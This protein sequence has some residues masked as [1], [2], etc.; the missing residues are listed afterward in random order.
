MENQNTPKVLLD[1][2]NLTTRFFTDDGI[3]LAVDNVSFQLMEGEILGIVGESGSGKS[4]TSMS[5]MRLIPIPPG[6]IT[7]GQVLL[8]GRDVLK[9][10]EKEMQDIRGNEIAM[11][12]Q[13]PMTALN[14]VYTVGA[15]I[16]EAIRQHSKMSKSKARERAI[17]LLK[18]VGI[19]APEKRVDDYPHQLSGGMRQRVV[20][21]IALAGNPSI[22]IADEPTTALDVTIQAQILRLIR[23]IKETQNKSVMLITH[24][25]GVIAQTCDRVIVMYGAEIVEQAPVRPLYK[26]PLHPYTEGLLSSIPKMDE[27]VE[28]L[29]VIEG[30]VPNPLALPAGCRFCSR[31]RKAQERCKTEKPMLHEAAPGRFVACHYPCEVQTDE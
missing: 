12:F 6:E 15:Q 16:V 9:C 20:I 13:E 26:N 19:P 4:V 25:L 27:D 17:E 24:D 28:R 18:L 1:V 21:A 11:I 30:M 2:R 10:S 7:E 8:N 23:E 5:T 31:C 22:L 29:N 3:V 14:P